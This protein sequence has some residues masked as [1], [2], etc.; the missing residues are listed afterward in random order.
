M[1]LRYRSHSSPSSRQMMSCSR[2]SISL[3]SLHSR[4]TIQDP[5]APTISTLK[6]LLP[7]IVELN[8]RKTIFIFLHVLTQELHFI[9]AN[10]TNEST[11][12]IN[13]MTLKTNTIYFKC[14]DKRFLWKSLSSLSK[15]VEAMKFGEKLERIS[16]VIRV[17]SWNGNR[18][19]SSAWNLLY[20]CRKDCPA[21]RTNLKRYNEV[22][23]SLSVTSGCGSLL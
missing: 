15:W 12:P 7:S 6:R 14:W 2:A 5:Q 1:S 4:F 20:R 17:V 8:A 16:V 11:R 18:D 9:K 22:F 21:K 13:P 23:L 10:A 19:Q 3:K